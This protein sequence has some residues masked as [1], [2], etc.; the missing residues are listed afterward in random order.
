MKVSSL[1]WDA[2]EIQVCKDLLK[3][4]CL[5]LGGAKKNIIFLLQRMMRPLLPKGR[6]Q[7]H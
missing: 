3:G 5:I 4:M 6:L 7:L 1:K 2:K